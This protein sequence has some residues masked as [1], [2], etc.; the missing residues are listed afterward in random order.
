[1]YNIIGLLDTNFMATNIGSKSV[2]VSV[3]QLKPVIVY[4]A[5]L[6]YIQ[7]EEVRSRFLIFLHHSLFFFLAGFIMGL[8]KNH[9]RKLPYATSS[10]LDS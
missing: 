7:W 8:V 9:S 6:S 2:R 3:E 10:N 5:S 1:M 4:N